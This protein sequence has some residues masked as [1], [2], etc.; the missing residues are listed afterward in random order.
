MFSWNRHQFSV[1][2][3]FVFLLFALTYVYAEQIHM[4]EYCS[5]WFGIRKE[6]CPWVLDSCPILQEYGNI[7]YKVKDSRSSA[8]ASQEGDGS[9]SE[10]ES[11]RDAAAHKRTGASARS[12]RHGTA[13]GCDDQPK[14]VMPVVSID[15]P[16][17]RIRLRV[18]FIRLFKKCQD[19]KVYLRHRD[20]L[21]VLVRRTMCLSWYK[22][23]LSCSILQCKEVP[24]RVLLVWKNSQLGLVQLQPES[25][26]VNTIRVCYNGWSLGPTD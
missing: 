22:T 17:W 2:L 13:A 24:I 7:S 18:V 9:P 10:A 8:H 4:I 1:C 25:L 14:C 6:F 21:F 16:D 3:C 19:Q 20:I 11:S 12:K 23:S 26:P 15:M 5:G